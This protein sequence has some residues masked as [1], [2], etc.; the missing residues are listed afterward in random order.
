MIKESTT[1]GFG[2]HPWSAIVLA[3]AEGRNGGNRN[4]MNGIEEITRAFGVVKNADKDMSVRVT[5]P[6]CGKRA[7]V[8][9][10]RTRWFVNTDAYCV[11]DVDG[12]RPS[13]ESSCGW[14]VSGDSW[15]TAATQARIR[16]SARETG[17]HRTEQH[18]DFCPSS[19]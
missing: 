8:I 9:R 19:D 6:E 16:A 11:G 18:G 13:R 3:R 15:G 10:T 17:I 14:R 1:E 5:C 12:T 2:P 7:V 4:E